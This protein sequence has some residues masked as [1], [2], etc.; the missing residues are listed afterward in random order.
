MSALFTRVP[1]IPLAVLE[2]VTD[3]LPDLHLAVA[4]EWF[5]HDLVRFELGRHFKVPPRLMASGGGAGF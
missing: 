4:G 1:R 2:P 3:K 5:P